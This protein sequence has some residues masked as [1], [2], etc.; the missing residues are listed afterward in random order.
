RKRNEANGEDNRDGSDENFGSNCGIE[1]PTEDRA[2]LALR[3]RQQRNFLATLL[4]SQ[5]V[6]MLSGGDEIGRT[7]RGNNNAYCQ[8]SELTWFAWPPTGTAANLLDFTRRL[9]RLRLDHP[10]FRRRRFFQGRRIHGS[11]VKDLSWLRPDGTEMTDEEWSNG[12][13]RSLGL[14]L[15]GD[16]IEEVDDEG[17]PVQDDTF[18]ILLNAHDLALS[19]ILPNHQAR[20]EWELVLDTRDWEPVLAGRL[21]KG[22]EPY[23]LEGQTLAVLRQRAKESD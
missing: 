7:Q 19:F 16:A 17:R 6:P 8:D 23:P 5:G 22:G 14:Q 12:K 3:E 15:A 18:L 1:G 2:V 9:I 20:I 21:F 10:A 13:S 4:L 11:A